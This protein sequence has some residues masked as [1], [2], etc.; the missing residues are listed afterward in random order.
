MNCNEIDSKI[1]RKNPDRERIEKTVDDAAAVG[2]AARV[3]KHRAA[4]GNSAAA[5]AAVLSGSDR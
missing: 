5:V 4:A 1:W 3:W 2:V